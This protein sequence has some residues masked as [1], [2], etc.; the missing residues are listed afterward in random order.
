MDSW[1]DIKQVVVVGL[2]ITGLSVVNHVRKK[3]RV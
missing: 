2:G 1:Q 3:H